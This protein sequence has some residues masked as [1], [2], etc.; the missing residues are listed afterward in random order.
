MVRACP[1]LLPAFLALCAA[2]CGGGE[3]SPAD[4][5]RPEWRLWPREYVAFPVPAAEHVRSDRLH[6]QRFVVDLPGNGDVQFRGN[7]W[8]L[9]SRL[10][11]DHVS[12]VQAASLVALRRALDEACSDPGLRTDPGPGTDAGT[13]RVPLRIRAN[14]CTPWSHVAEVIRQAL[15]PPARIERLQWSVHSSVTA[16]PVCQEAAVVATSR[17][18]DPLSIEIRGR[19]LE[20]GMLEVRL[21]VGDWSRTAREVCNVNAWIVSLDEEPVDALDAWSGATAVVQG[22]RGRHGAVELRITGEPE[23]VAWRHVVRV[24]D[25]LLGAGVREVHLPA[26]GIRLALAEPEDTSRPPFVYPDDPVVTPLVVF[27]SVV[28]A[29]SAFVLTFAGAARSRRVRPRRP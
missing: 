27:L 26:L 21:S 9:G 14:R 11:E 2:G 29:L 3:P 10:S 19:P 28:A 25:L 7:V 12:E 8:P 23:G 13:C 17:P 22:Q 4:P 6:E 20:F 16:H 1:L 18:A 15:Q 24:L 5:L